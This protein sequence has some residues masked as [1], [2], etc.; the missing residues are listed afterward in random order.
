M[1]LIGNFFKRWLPVAAAVAAAVSCS[2]QAFVMDIEMK[3]ASSSR[4]D[5]SGKSMSVVYLD[6]LSGRDTTFTK[7]V[8]EGFARAIE[9]EYFDG[10]EAVN[11]YTMTKDRAGV[12]SAKDTLVNL[13]L[14]TGDDVVFL[15]DSPQFGEVSLGGRQRIAGGQED[16]SNVAYATIPFKLNLY[17][18]DSMAKEDTV[19]MFR[20]TST[21]R[22]AL[23]FGDSSSEESLKLSV[24]DKLAEA[25][26]TIGEK[27]AVSF[28]PEWTGEALTFLYY[29]TSA[30]EKAAE[31]AYGYRWKEAVDAWMA[32]LDTDNM[33]KRSCA[34]YNIAVAL[35]IL[36]DCQ[37][38]EKWLDMSDR[39]MP[40]SLSPSLRQ[41]ILARNRQQ[42]RTML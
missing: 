24:W 27:S 11:I 16:S 7:G 10:R 6:D 30:W 3:G 4:L 9:K 37:L 15:F 23:F 33:E 35:Y 13:I 14:D 25:G 41:K 31:L 8:A 34:E 2:P 39:D 20:G 26:E 32:L 29:E 22:Q 19:R 28:I 1:G 36:G 5:L 21:V 17:A 12:Y 38:A 40:I 18:Y 42:S